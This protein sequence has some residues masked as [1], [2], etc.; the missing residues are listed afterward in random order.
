M[1]EK[2]APEVAERMET[3]ILACHLI[4]ATISINLKATMV[5]EGIQFSKVLLH[6]RDNP[7]SSESVA[8]P[9]HC[10]RAHTGPRQRKIPIWKSNIP[11][12]QS[13]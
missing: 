6:I 12:A 11:T 2:D 10:R 13:Y 8:E 7:S 5:L 9:L 1:G 3:G 4:A